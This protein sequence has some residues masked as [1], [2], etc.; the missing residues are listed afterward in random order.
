MVLSLYVSLSLAQQEVVLDTLCV[1]DPP[2]HLATEY[3][4]GYSYQWNVMGGQII[5]PSDSS[6]ILVDW[7]SRPGKFPISLVTFDT[8][9]GCTGDT[10]DAFIY[11]V[12]PDQARGKAPEAVCAG[13]LV[14]LESQVQGN[15][16]WQN[17]S[18]DPFLTFEARKDTS[19]YLVAINEYCG[20]DTLYFNVSVE[21]PPTASMNT[22]PDTVQL[23]T[24]LR[25]YFTG[26]AEQEAD[27]TWLLNDF[28]RGSGPV[29]DITFTEFGMQELSQVVSNNYC[30][31]TIKKYV[32]VADEF[33]AHFPNAFT[34]NNDGKNDLWTFKGVGH[35]S[36]IAEVYNRWG[37]MVYRWDEQTPV[38]GWDGTEQ[39]Q[40]SKIDTY[41]YRVE[42]TDMRGQTHFYTNSFHLVR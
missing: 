11:L 2:S 20:N 22:L 35:D 37:E 40:P 5:S 4:E 7:G 12:S 36:F 23:N 19:I 8:E 39:G 16:Q 26:E 31:D 29:F 24:R 13:D 28:A 42:I 27:I 21:D 10:I 15:Y 30:H 1:F 17:G 14:T 41:I 34:P 33:T 9:T 6:T 38:N 25:V 3:Y 32:Y 18:R